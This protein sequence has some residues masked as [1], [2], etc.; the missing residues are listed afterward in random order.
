MNELQRAVHQ[1][2]LAEA[3]VQVA[4]SKV[5]V[6]E[7]VHQSPVIANESLRELVQALMDSSEATR[8]LAFILAIDENALL[9]GADLDDVVPPILEH[10][11]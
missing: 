2:K 6:A 4:I 5:M 7:R 10:V 9:S 1:R 11:E 3:A 8:H